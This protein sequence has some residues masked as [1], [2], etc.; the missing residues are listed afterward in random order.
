MSLRKLRAKAVRE[1][2]KTGNQTEVCKFE[3]KPQ[4]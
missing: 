4:G 1:K 2:K 3:T